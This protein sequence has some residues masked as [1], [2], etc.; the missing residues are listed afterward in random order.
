MEKQLSDLNASETAVRWLR[1][2]AEKDWVTLFELTQLTWRDEL[3]GN[4]KTALIKK[5]FDTD[6]EVLG[7]PQDVELESDLRN[8]HVLKHAVVPVVLQGERRRLRVTVVCERAPYKPMPRE[9]GGR[10]G[11]NPNSLRPVDTD[12]AE[13]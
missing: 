12:E 6:L 7:K 13:T 10:W 11:V 8:E 4:P 9:S 5:F 2:V 3:K 1:A